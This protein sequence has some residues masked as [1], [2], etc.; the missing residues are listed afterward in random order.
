MSA[1]SSAA[2]TIEDGEITITADLLRQQ[3]GLSV[4]A[5]KAQTRRG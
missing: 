2:V 5:L 1:L 3:L 4:G